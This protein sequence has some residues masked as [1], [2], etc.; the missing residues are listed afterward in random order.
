MRKYKNKI[1]LALAFVLLFA[2][3]LA[4]SAFALKGEE[5]S[6]TYATATGIDHSYPSSSTNGGNAV[7]LPK[8]TT[9]EGYS[10][11]WV[12]PDGS[13]YVGGS[14]VVF[15]ESVTLT[16]V[17][18]YDI[19]SA[20]ALYEYARSFSDSHLTSDDLKKMP[21]NGITVRL[22]DDI[23]LTQAIELNTT[24]G[25]YMNII[26]NGQ[27]LTVDKSLSGALGGERFG[28]R[29]YGTG[30]VKY[31]GTGALVRLDSHTT[32]GASNILVV[33][34]NVKID[35]PNATL[36]KDTKEGYFS[37]YP[38]I[39]IYGTVNCKTILEVANSVNR[40]PTINIQSPAFVTLNGDIAVSAKDSEGAG[41]AFSIT[42][43]GGTIVAKSSNSFF[44]VADAKYTLKGGSFKFSYAQDFTSTKEHMGSG[45]KAAYRLS[46][47]YLTVFSS[48]CADHKFE[49]ADT[50]AASCQHETQSVYRCTTCKTLV[51]F[52]DGDRVA[53]VFDSSKETKKNPT[54]TT[55]GNI[56]KRCS[57]CACEDYTFFS[58]DPMGD[59]VSVKV[60]TGD[61]ATKSET[62]K[63]ENLFEIDSNYVING[64]KDF[65]D[66]KAS[67]VVEII[68][69]AGIKGINIKTDNSTL[70]KLVF[71]TGVDIEIISL[72]KLTGLTSIEIM[73]VKHVRFFAN[74]APDS[75]ESIKSEKVGAKVSFLD[76]AFNGKA[77]LKELVLSGLSEYVFG[78]T[79]FKA[80]GITRLELK[81]NAKL[82]FTGESAFHSS[83]LEYL[84]V[85]RGITS[86]DKKPFDSTYYMQKIVFMDLTTLSDGDFSNMNQGANGCVV[87][88][89]ASKLTLGATTFA[90]SHGIKLYTT[91]E[92]TAGFAECTSFTIIQNVKHAY[93][94]EEKKPT[95]YEVGYTKYTNDDCPCGVNDGTATEVYENVYT[96][97]TPSK[98]SY[99][100]TNQTYPKTSHTE[101]ENPVIK[102]LDGYTKNGYYV[103]ECVV[104][105]E[106]LTGSA[107]T[108]APLVKSLGFSVCEYSDG[109]S[110]SVKYV[111]NADIMSEFSKSIGS[112]FECGTVFAIREALDDET[113]LNDDGSA[114]DGVIKINT[115]SKKYASLTTKV[116]GLNDKQKSISFIMCT[117]IIEN[118]EISYIQDNEIVKNPSGVSYKE[119]KELAD[120][121]EMMQTPIDATDE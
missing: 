66:Y 8:G 100:F 5:I 7:E 30:T 9:D 84:Y 93:V 85:G 45:C 59:N 111:L 55:L 103:K 20:E 37:G 34:A 61:G 91:A 41:N 3:M 64:I 97:G 11:H 49:L 39:N 95:C 90:K 92:V 83:K 109:G 79:S 36:G 108:C 23:T 113:P 112:E 42:V 13:A 106:A 29:F 78:T 22:L 104:C 14:S 51:Y 57:N 4:T 21:E 114:K 77:N 96:N 67:Q 18:A 75:L 101:S 47:S 68:I 86:L 43:N 62:V 99:D 12:A 80:T 56:V 116:T 87:Y 60:D 38:M 118:G 65:G 24:L 16:P 107:K 52:T 74:C 15:Y 94:K 81:D 102:Y 119:V 33:G 82:T 53:H 48:Q 63:V 58:Y 117:Y 40:K 25:A 72:A 98:N 54:P 76:N 6:I 19:S 27:T 10:Y 69:P 120:F 110:M 73:D 31:E 2:A 1:V 32:G 121:I 89:H 70:K 46:T 26:M 50:Y 35:A 28:T 71:D 105:K 88:H 17:I 115:T 44:S